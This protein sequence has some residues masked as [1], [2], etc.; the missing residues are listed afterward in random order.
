RVLW[1]LAHTPT[2]RVKIV[3][4]SEELAEER[5]RFIRDAIASN[6]RVRLVFPHLQ[7]DRPWEPG[8]FSVARHGRLIGPSVAALG[9]EAASTGARA[10]LLV[11]DD[12]V[13]VK[14]LRSRA[15]RERVTAAF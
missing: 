8:R 11:C 2:L 15:D 4:A 1:E 3:C 7:P 14:A 12:V 5:G 13:D 9:I 6:L 10:D